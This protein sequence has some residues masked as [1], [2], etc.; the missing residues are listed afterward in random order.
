MRSIHSRQ[1]YPYSSGTEQCMKNDEFS[2][3]S[4]ITPLSHRLIHQPESSN[5][6]TSTIYHLYTS[7]IYYLFYI[8]STDFRAAAW[9]LAACPFP[10]FRIPFSIPL[11]SSAPLDSHLNLWIPSTTPG[12]LGFAAAL[13]ILVGAVQKIL[14]LPK[15]IVVLFLVLLSLEIEA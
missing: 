12:D 7:I 1:E 13:E 4:F 10:C 9:V 3:I 6:A 5:P 2:I 11:T 8:L 15:R 14:G